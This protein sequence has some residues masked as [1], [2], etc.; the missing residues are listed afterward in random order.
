MVLTAEGQSWSVAVDERRLGGIGS[1][2][3]KGEF[4]DV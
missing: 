2:C 4:S 1:R 3:P